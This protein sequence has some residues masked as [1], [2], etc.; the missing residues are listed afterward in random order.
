M[1]TID[2]LI[3]SSI[4]REI[5]DTVP[6][7]TQEITDKF[8]STMPAR[9]LH[10][11]RELHL[12]LPI[13]QRFKIYADI[14]NAN[15]QVPFDIQ[16][17][18]IETVHLAT[19]AEVTKLVDSLSS[20]VLRSW[21]GLQDILTPALCLKIYVQILNN[22]SP[23]DQNII[24][25]AIAALKNVSDEVKTLFARSIRREVLLADRG[26]RSALTH[27]GRLELFTQ[28]C[29]QYRD[30]GEMLVLNELVSGWHDEIV[31]AAQHGS[32]T[33]ILALA[34]VT[35]R[36]LI[37]QWRDLRDTLALEDHL[38]LCLA[39]WNGNAPTPANADLRDEV[40]DLLQILPAHSSGWKDVPHAFLFEKRSFRE[41]LPKAERLVYL[42]SRISDN[43]QTDKFEELINE[44]QATLSLSVDKKLWQQVPLH[45]LVLDPIRVCA[46]KALLVQ[47]IAEDIQRQGANKY[48]AVLVE[49]IKNTDES[50]RNDLWGIIPLHVKRLEPILWMLPTVEQ[51]G[52][53]CS[54]IEDMDHE[55][56]HQIWDTLTQEIRLLC[57]YYFAKKD[58]GDKLVDLA[59]KEGDPIVRAGLI[60]LRAKSTIISRKNQAFEEAHNLLEKHVVDQAWLTDAAL[61]LDG[62]LPHC[63]PRV[64]KY[65]EARAW[66]TRQDKELQAPFASRAF[67][68]RARSECSLQRDD[69]I[70][71]Y[72]IVDST[73]STAQS[74]ILS[75]AHLY[76][77]CEQEWHD[78]SLMELLAS[79]GLHSVLDGLAASEYVRKFSGWINRL[80]EIRERLR[81]SICGG[82]MVP[83]RRYAKFLARFNMTIASCSQGVGHDQNVY[84]NQCWACESIIDSRESPVFREKYYLCTSCGSGPQYSPTYAQ[85]SVC[86]KCESTE[87]KPLPS[88]TDMLC[89]QSCNH[90]LHLPSKLKLTGSGSSRQYGSTNYEDR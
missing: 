47:R 88:R 62:L 41:H 75:G 87:M 35:P 37:V 77:N 17:D 64:V 30:Q 55:Q 61:I 21:Q 68:P 32:P 7:V 45:I 73:D 51:A 66:P 11:W 3:E 76:A 83:N 27:D 8:I 39:M 23:V 12:A 43:A 69:H 54:L 34:R 33:V 19:Q 1:L 63:Q 46:P 81:C 42:L 2:R 22:E 9:L 86:P 60:L 40:T 38:R 28:A 16:S 25:S 71:L 84:F 57:I 29:Q 56:W 65:C 85:G 70:H 14:L 20:T 48:I 15:E 5:L 36:S 31:F 53:V 18:V 58:A 4:D 80:N 67:C 72:P 24:I 59:E 13:A 78:W 49:E 79:I 74:Q 44:L 10:S 50:E 6:L 82:T 90:T 26:L 52:A 89:C